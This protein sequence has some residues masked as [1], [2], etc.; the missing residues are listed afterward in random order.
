MG[1]LRWAPD[2]T[3][4]VLA[5]YLNDTKF[6]GDLWHGEA[7]YKITDGWRAKLS[8]DLLDGGTETPLGTYKRND[9]ATVSVLAQF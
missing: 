4:T 7:T 5:S 3:W 1:A 6:K 2:E 9:R 8:A